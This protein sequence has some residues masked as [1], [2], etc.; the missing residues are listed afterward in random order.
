[1]RKEFKTYE[2]QLDIL[3]KKG[4][5]TDEKSLNILKRNN[6]YFL[7]N[8]Y[9]NIFIEPNIKPN[10]FK[11]GTHFNEIV[12]LYDFDRELRMIVLK[13]IITIENTLKSIL[14]YEFS[15]KYGYAYRDLSSYDTNNNDPKR[16]SE[17]RGFFKSINYSIK[18][19]LSYEKHMQY[20]NKNYDE[21]PLWVII[22]SLTFG[23]MVKFYKYLKEEEQKR[24]ANEFGITREELYNFLLVLLYFRN[25]SAH[26]QRLFD[27]KSESRILRN[28][29][30]YILGLKDRGYNDV[31]AVIITFKCLLVQKDFNMVVKELDNNYK[32][33]FNRLVTINEEIVF[34][35]TGMRNYRELLK[36]KNWYH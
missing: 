30:H 31:M 4:L 20:Y 9:K 1:M 8:R 34:E 23:L 29:Y 22:N 10:I 35:K 19:S 26:N 21:I 12:A 15:K 25:L 28:K 14:S 33:L 13:Y 11:S 7:I 32:T 2:E 3:I 5:K 6:Y 18:K 24:I 17:L 16:I 27:E 36:I